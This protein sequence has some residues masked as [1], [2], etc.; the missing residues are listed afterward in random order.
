MPEKILALLAAF[1]LGVVVTMMLGSKMVSF[2]LLHSPRLRAMVRAQL[3]RDDGV[4]T[5]PVVQDCADAAAGKF[6]AVTTSY[7]DMNGKRQHVGCIDKPLEGETLCAEHLR[8]TKGKQL[9]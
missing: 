3:D 1:V 5:D 7:I 8:Q 9:P 4:E 6:C 2:A